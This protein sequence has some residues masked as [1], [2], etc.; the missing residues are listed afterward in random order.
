ML[1]IKHYEVMVYSGEIEIK[2]EN[3]PFEQNDYLATFP[4]NLFDDH[5]SSTFTVNITVVDM[6]GQRST[7][8]SVNVPIN[9]T[10][11]QITSSSEY[12]ISCTNMIIHFEEARI[13][14]KWYMFTM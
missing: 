9:T 8:S 13:T 4:Q 6:V 7:T 10:Q 3:I 11:F 2:A 14:V 12:L 5:S 1:A